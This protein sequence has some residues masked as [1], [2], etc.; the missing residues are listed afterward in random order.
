MKHAQTDKAANTSEHNQFE[1]SVVHVSKRV[2]TM[3]ESKVWRTGVMRPESTKRS[4]LPS[5]D[6]VLHRED[7]YMPWV[8]VCTRVAVNFKA[9]SDLLLSE[10]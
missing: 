2:C 7:C 10:L 3:H 8:A 6:S 9:F 5:T 1:S 4:I